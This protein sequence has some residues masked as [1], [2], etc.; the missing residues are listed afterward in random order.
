MSTRQD[1]FGFYYFDN[2]HFYSKL[3]AIQASE[4][5]NKTLQWNFN[6]EVYSSYDWSIEPIESLEDLYRDRAQQIRDKYDYLILWL[7][8]GADSANI[9]NAFIN[10]DIK[11]DEVASYVNYEATGD[12]YNFLNGEI[13]NVAIPMVEKAKEKQPWLKHTLIDLPSLTMDHF[14]QHGTKFD[15]IYHM[16]WYLTPNSMTRQDIKMKI[17]EWANMINSGKKVCFLHGVDKPRVTCNR[18]KGQYHFKFVDLI[19]NS[20]TANMQINDNPWEFDELFYWSPD[21]P[22]I[23]IKQGHVI[24]QYMKTA[25]EYITLVEEQKKRKKYCVVSSINEEFYFLEL[26]K[27]NSLI[28]P[29]HTPVMYQVKAP[30]LFFTPRDEWFFKLPDSD[31]A[32]HAWRMGL[33]Y[34]WNEMP[35]S[36]KS[37]PNKMEAGFN[38]M[39][40]KSY[41]LGS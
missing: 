27:L 17:P 18:N 9:L 13:Y 12:K 14:A 40:S 1:K 34:L 39:S 7:S 2:L 8:G 24:K 19:D 38:M 37:N 33:D 26:I 3:E 6:D 20:V 30:S 36:M 10:N 15:W 25:T 35:D 23:P 11:I 41:N 32:K 29:W 4:K 28:Y 22:K 31:P 21:A 16:N 5:H